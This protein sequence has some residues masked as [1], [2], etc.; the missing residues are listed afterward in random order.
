MSYTYTIKYYHHTRNART[1]GGADRAAQEMERTY[2]RGG[3][4]ATVECRDQAAADA[5]AEYSLESQ[6]TYDVRVAGVPV[7]M[8]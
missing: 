5:M 4:T 1:P 7:W 3:K 2:G 6:R 8:S